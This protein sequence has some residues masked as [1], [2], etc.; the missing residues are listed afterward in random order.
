MCF[1]RRFQIAFLRE[2]FSSKRAHVGCWSSLSLKTFDCDLVVLL[3]LLSAVASYL[4]KTF[5]KKWMTDCALVQQ[6]L[7]INKVNKHCL[8]VW[9]THGHYKRTHNR[10]STWTNTAY[11]NSYIFNSRAKAGNYYFRLRAC[12][13]ASVRPSSVPRVF[14]ANSG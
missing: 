12:V 8:R 11:T 6:A 4:G 2:Q 9:C 7:E 1:E 13:R 10:H 14:F 5:Y 3:F